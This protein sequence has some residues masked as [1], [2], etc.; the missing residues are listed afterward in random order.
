MNKEI[1]EEI[2]EL[3]N[4]EKSQHVDTLMK[5][6]DMATQEETTEEQKPH[7]APQPRSKERKEGAG[8]EP[9]DGYWEH[10]NDDKGSFA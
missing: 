1:V 9:G 7:P 10:Y 6:D 2:N 5:L 4:A 8:Y 3:F